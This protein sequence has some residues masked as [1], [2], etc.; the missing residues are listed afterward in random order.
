MTQKDNPAE[1]RQLQCKNVNWIRYIFGGMVVIQEWE[2][3]AVQPYLCVDD[4][5]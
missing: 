1:C 3:M 4:S 5:S 2:D